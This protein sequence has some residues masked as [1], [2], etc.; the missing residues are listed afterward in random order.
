MKIPA[1][2][3]LM[4]FA[5]AGVCIAEDLSGTWQLMSGEYLNQSGEVINY[6]QAGMRAIKIYSTTHF[7]FTS[8]KSADFWAAGTGTYTQANGLYTET[9]LMNSFGEPVGA[10]YEFQSE[11]KGNCLRNERWQ[12]S[13]RVEYEVWCRLNQ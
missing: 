12:E 2:S 6:Q 8:M 1:L 7:S 13:V 4:C 3:A 9:L 5:Y 11:L 10:R